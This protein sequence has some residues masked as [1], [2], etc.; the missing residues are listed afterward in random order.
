MKKVLKNYFFCSLAGLS[1]QLISVLALFSTS[2][3]LRAESDIEAQRQLFLQASQALESNQVKKFRTIL[4]KLDDYP[5]QPYLISDALRSHIHR[6]SAEKVSGFLNEYED[7]PFSYH[8]RATWLSSLAKKQDWK[9]YLT[10]FDNR[11]NTR[12][13]CLA[14]QARLNLGRLDGLNDQIRRIWIRGYSQ[15]SECDVA[16]RYFLETDDNAEK[17]IWLRIEKAFK[18]RRPNLARY[19]AKKLNDKDRKIVDLWYQA[20]RNPQQTLKQLQEADDDAINR[21]IIVHAIDRLTRRNSIAGREAWLELATKFQFSQQQRDRLAQ[22]IALSSAYQHRPEARQLLI[23]L[24][25]ELKNDQAFLWLARIQLRTQDWAGLSRT[26]NEMPA[27]LQQENEWRYWLARSLEMQGV[28]GRANEILTSLSGGGS[29]YGFLAA[30]RVERQYYIE[31]E[32]AF[33]DVVDEEAMLAENPHMLR[34]R[35]LFFVNRPVDARREWFQA[36]RELDTT[37]IKQAAT[38]ASSWNWHDSAIK[39][40]ARTSHRQDY[41]LRFPMPYK[42][43]VLSHAEKKQ[44][45]PSVI[46]GVMRRES[47][48]DPQARSRVGALGLMQLMPATARSVANSLGLKK[49]ARADIL[50]IENNINLGTQYFRSVM[51]RFDNNV[52]L[53]AAAYIAGPRNVKKWLPSEDN[54]LPADLWVETV[55]FN[56][57]RKYVQA[58]LAYAT[59]F[60]KSRGKDTLISSRMHDIRA[61]Y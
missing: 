60:D 3:S 57:T 26:I 27:H 50:K 23:E 16:F 11:D 46:Y 18:A 7:F 2:D 58:V 19:L 38:L 14:F 9:S 35:E 42:Q 54:V 32:N 17:A 51:D 59:V 47:L 21:K 36:L 43:Q 52:S 28:A 31:Q 37:Q 45:D 41:S 10:H 12:L 61:S 13:Q 40:V 8:I 20:H 34:A 4:A 33:A 53:A 15:P 6:A 22:R 55:P 30:D 48:F 39:T 1:L 5:L 56:E 29:Y 44:L 49:L 24:P 25:A